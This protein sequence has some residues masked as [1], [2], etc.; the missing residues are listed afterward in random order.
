MAPFKISLREF[1]ESSKVG[2]LTKVE[3]CGG[4]GREVGREVGREEGR[5]VDREVD[6]GRRGESGT[7][8]V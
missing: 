7:L 8:F 2:L 5:E 6:R 3:W 4:R 1:A